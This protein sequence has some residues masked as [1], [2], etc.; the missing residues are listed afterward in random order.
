M[1]RPCGCCGA[2]NCGF[3]IA[4][5]IYTNGSTAFQDLLGHFEI[6]INGFDAGVIGGISPF[7]GAYIAFLYQLGPTLT[8]NAFENHPCAYCTTSTSSVLP[9]NLAWLNPNRPNTISVTM[10]DIGSAFIG[11]AQV[12][13]VF[14]AQVV[15]NV[16]GYG[17]VYSGPYSLLGAI[18]PGGDF[19]TFD[20]LPK[21][22]IG[23]TKSLTFETHPCLP[24]PC[25]Q[26]PDNGEDA[27]F[28]FSLPDAVHFGQYFTPPTNPPVIVPCADQTHIPPGTCVL[29]HYNDNGG[30]NPIINAPA[31]PGC[32]WTG[33]LPYH[34]T[35]FNCGGIPRYDVDVAVPVVL[36]SSLG[37]P[38]FWR[39][40]FFRPDV[41]GFASG[42][43]IIGDYA[44]SA[45]HCGGPSTFTGGGVSDPAAL[46]PDCP[47]WPATITVEL[48]SP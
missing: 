29:A 36:F 5:S 11:Q 38:N 21:N 47:A 23:V 32:A 18:G 48:V 45:F 26:C 39:L 46:P 12:D 14:D 17:W 28:A 1:G 43:D 6:K 13:L 40:R 4:I 44:C 3:A 35:C 25:L 24:T 42:G 37:Q 10:L 31:T 30:G 22:E 33:S 27:E 34:F 20:R 19:L 41:P 16:P 2:G 7:G 15:R 9:L 8:Q